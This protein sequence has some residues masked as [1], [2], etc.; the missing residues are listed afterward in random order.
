MSLPDGYVIQ[1]ACHDCGHV[2]KWKEYDDDT[3]WFCAFGAPPRPPS[4]S[5]FMKDFALESNMNSAD[6]WFD[7]REGR[8]VHPA[9]ICP[10]WTKIDTEETGKDDNR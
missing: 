5:A 3:M 1:N 10:R 4:G 7:W 6:E 8:E 2:F 9:G